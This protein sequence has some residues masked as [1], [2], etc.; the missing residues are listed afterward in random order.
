QTTDKPLIDA[1]HRRIDGQRL[2]LIFDNCEHVLDAAAHLSEALLRRSVQATILATSREPL[3]IGD[4]QVYRLSTLSVPD[5]DAD[6]ETIRQSDSVLL[7]V[8]R[9]QQQQHEFSLTPASARSV[10]RLCARLD[11]IPFAL[12]LAAALVPTYT[13][14]EI[15]ARLD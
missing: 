11:G 6:S 8:N 5:S 14:D 2:L 12:E 7:F 15:N 10:A 3:R 1:L 9:A 13:I 4:E